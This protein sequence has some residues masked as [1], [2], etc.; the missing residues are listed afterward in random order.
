MRTKFQSKN[1]SASDHLGAVNI[2]GRIILKLFLNKWGDRVWS[3]LNWLRVRA[4][5]E[6]L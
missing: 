4:G 6:L 3:G 5:A 2:H 1:V